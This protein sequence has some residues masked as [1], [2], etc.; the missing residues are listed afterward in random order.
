MLRTGGE[1]I[2]ARPMGDS[3]L[4]AVAY[5]DARSISAQPE[6]SLPRSWAYG[7]VSAAPTVK[8]IWVSPARL[9]CFRSAPTYSLDVATR[10]NP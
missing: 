1:E 3:A 6:I 5:A 10:T 8:A 9:D 4:K 2:S 7:T